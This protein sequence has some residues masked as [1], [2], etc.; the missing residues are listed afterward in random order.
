MVP[1]LSSHRPGQDT[2]TF[3]LM[4]QPCFAQQSLS[5]PDGQPPAGT[6]FSSTTTFPPPPLGYFNYFLPV[7]LI[8]L[9]VTSE[10]NDFNIPTLT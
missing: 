4:K 2:R 3:A 10:Y 5:L 1:V 8:S 9:T 6:A 7:H